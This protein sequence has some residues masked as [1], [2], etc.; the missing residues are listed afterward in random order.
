MFDPVPSGVEPDDEVA[1]VTSV[2]AG[3]FFDH[4]ERHLARLVHGY[5]EGL[6]RRR[7]H[8]HELAGLGALCL[9]GSIAA[10]GFLVGKTTPLDTTASLAPSACGGA[11]IASAELRLFSKEDKASRMRMR[12]EEARVV[13]VT[14]AGRVHLGLLVE[15]PAKARW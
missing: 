8:M 1:Q 13:I 15:N 4:E 7:R 5:S 3:A 11:L 12:L 6:S 9:G 10:F 14:D 2:D